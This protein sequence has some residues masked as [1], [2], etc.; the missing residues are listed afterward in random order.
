M[1]WFDTVSGLPSGTVTSRFTVSS[2][3]RWIRFTGTVM[4]LAVADSSTVVG[5]ALLKYTCSPLT[6]V[7]VYSNSSVQ[8]PNERASTEK[9]NIV[10]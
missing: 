5:S 3:L 1:A 8:E 9:N 2:P 7:P 6:D 4:L 10:K